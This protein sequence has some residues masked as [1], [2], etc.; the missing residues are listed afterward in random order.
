[1]GC[2]ERTFLLVGTL[3][4]AWVFPVWSQTGSN[5]RSQLVVSVYDDVGISGS[6]LGEVERHAGMIFGQGGVD[7]VWINC[8]SHAEVVAAGCERI[9]PTGHF[10]LRFVHKPGRSANDVVGAAF[11]SDQGIGC[12]GDVFYDRAMERSQDWDVTLPELLGTVAAHEIGHLL[13]G[14]NSHSNSGI[15]KAKWQSGELRRISNGNLGFTGDQ[16]ERMRVR[17][18]ATHGVRP[19]QLAVSNGPPL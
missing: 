6:V 19:M 8:S 2:V 11:L 9:D 17:L 5:E 14:S 3:L 15:M 10:A 7:V 4:L 16:A 13:L 12:Y 18:T 1:M